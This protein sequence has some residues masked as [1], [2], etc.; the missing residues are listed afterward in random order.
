VSLQRRT[1]IIPSISSSLAAPGIGYVQISCFQPTTLQELDAAL[2]ELRKQDVKALILD[3][4]GNSGGLVDVAI[5]VARRF[6]THGVIVSTE[7][8]DPSESTIYQARNPHALTL[9]LVV[10]IDGE[11]ASSAEIL[12]GALKE[13]RRATLVGQTTYG[14]GCSQGLRYLPMG[15]LKVPPE[16]GGVSLGGLRI[17]MT[18]YFSPTGQPYSERGVAPHLFVERPLMPSMEPLDPQFEAARQEAQRLV[19]MAR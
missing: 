13:N 7:H 2:A 3:L 4:R 10:L 15:L 11:T 16:E 5:E 12:A 19:E 14:K 8:Q 17:T 18:R 1:L 9:P 6:L